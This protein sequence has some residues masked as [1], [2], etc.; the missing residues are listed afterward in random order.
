MGFNEGKW[1]RKSCGMRMNDGTWRRK[2]TFFI[3]RIRFSG[4]EW[5]QVLQLDW[6]FDWSQSSKWM[7]FLVLII[8]KLSH[9]PFQLQ[10]CIL[11]SITRWSL[12]TTPPNCIS[13]TIYFNQLRMSSWIIKLQSIRF[14]LVGCLVSSSERWSKSRLEID[15]SSYRRENSCR[16]LM[17]SFSSLAHKFKSFMNQFARLLIA[18]RRIVYRESATFEAFQLTLKWILELFSCSSFISIFKPNKQI[19]EDVQ[20]KMPAEI[21]ANP[22]KRFGSLRESIDSQSFCVTPIYGLKKKL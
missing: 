22:I 2:T 18:P 21:R 10:K 12:S 6:I 16:W 15:K 11:F 5:M 9:W 13:I 20:P 17:F 1:E 14:K 4:N 19:K 3:A 8:I 7:R